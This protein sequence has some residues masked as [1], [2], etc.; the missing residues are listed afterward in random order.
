MSDSSSEVVVSIAEAAR[1]LGVSPVAVVRHIDEG[2]L[3]TRRVNHARGLHVVLPETPEPALQDAPKSPENGISTEASTKEFQASVGY[4]EATLERLEVDTIGVFRK[5]VAL[6]NEQLAA[7]DR[8]LAQRD[9]QV[10]ELHAL[11]AASNPKSK[12]RRGLMR[13]LCAL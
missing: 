9:R 8:Q 10:A 6:L 4:L 7:K 13:R 2:Q 5:V 1:R 11:L 3:Q 12:E